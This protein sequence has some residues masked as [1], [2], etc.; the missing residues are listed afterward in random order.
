MNDFYMK[1]YN[2]Y[3]VVYEGR[4]SLQSYEFVNNLYGRKCMI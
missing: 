1:Q 3:S 2:F 4:K